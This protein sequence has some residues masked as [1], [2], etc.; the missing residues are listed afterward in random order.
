ML[1]VQSSIASQTPVSRPVREAFTRLR[2][3][4]KHGN[5]S[6]LPFH[7]LSILIQV[8]KIAPLLTTLKP[9][10]C[11]CFFEQVTKNDDF[12]TNHHE[13]EQPIWRHSQPSRRSRLWRRHRV[14]IPPP[15]HI[16]GSE[17]SVSSTRQT[18]S[19]YLCPAAAAA[20]S[21]RGL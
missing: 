6:L 20:A 4:K 15:I 2:G 1:L 7:C 8:S 13:Q 10:A 11:L 5:S 9:I 18:P 16:R 21:L 17:D 3:G 19:N 14:G 12:W